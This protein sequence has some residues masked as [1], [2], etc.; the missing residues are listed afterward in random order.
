M[1]KINSFYLLTITLAL[2]FPWGNRILAQH[3]EWVDQF[4]GLGK[5]QGRSV[6][7]DNQGNVYTAGDFEDIVDVDPGPDE[8]LLT[9]NGRFDIFITKVD[10]TGHL[11]WA[12]Q[13]GGSRDDVANGIAIDALGNVLT[14]GSFR[15]TVDFDPGPGST[16]LK[17]ESSFMGPGGGQ[18]ASGSDMFVS[19]LDSS[20]NF[21]WVKQIGGNLSDYGNA[22]TVDEL[23]NVYTTGEFS[24][25][26]S[27]Y[28]DS[29]D[30]DPGPG[31]HNFPE[32]GACITKWDADGNYL[33]ARQFG[34]KY[35]ITGFG[36]VGGL[37]HYTE[38]YSVT[39]ESIALDKSGNLCISGVLIP[40]IHNDDLDPGPG[41][42]ILEAIG[43][44][45]AIV[46]K[47]DNDGNFI[48]AK[49][50]GGVDAKAQADDLVVDSTGH[51]YVT[52]N[53]TEAVDFDPDVTLQLLQSVVTS[54]KDIF[55]F[56][57]NDS[58]KLEWAKS[59]GGPGEDMGTSIALGQDGNVYTTG[60]FSSTADFDPGPDV[61]PLIPDDY[62]VFISKLSNMGDFVGAV[63]F[64]G[65]SADGG[66]G[67]EADENNNIY[68]TGYFSETADFDPAPGIYDLTSAGETDVFLQKMNQEIM[69]ALNA[70]REIMTPGLQVFPNPVKDNA[71]LSF[72]EHCVLQYEI[73]LLDVAGKII[74]K[75][76]GTTQMGENTL[77][78]YCGNLP[79]GVYYILLTTD[80]QQTMQLLTIH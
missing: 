10:A 17:I 7:V 34:N 78:L 40:N 30:L 51:I 5:D 69:S 15:D 8:Y 46:L 74:Q 64:G 11:I 38:Y 73:L 72:A 48:W 29:V 65:P 32:G 27:I 33:W 76:S 56:K 54:T 18:Y 57:L 71:H 77:D 1:K 37:W 43:K 36:G 20:G 42:Y 60:S 70:E 49:Q 9:S 50:F 19:K 58:G 6:A 52:G 55:V 44:Q 13:F 80:R 16:L 23:G 63:H 53:F 31:A 12:K 66:N 47:L 2:L 67:I 14:T 41:S 3:F 68:C 39:L 75:H 45:D 61:F 28:L 79:H 26:D 35:H 62:D 22:V 24:N 21:I 25:V 59:I 4:G